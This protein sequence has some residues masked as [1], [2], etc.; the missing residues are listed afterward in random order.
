MGQLNVR[1]RLLLGQDIRGGG[2]TRTT[3]SMVHISFKPP[4]YQLLLEEAE[5]EGLSVTAY[6]RSIVLKQLQKEKVK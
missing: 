1:D 3:H 4:D 6:V 2:M 5:R